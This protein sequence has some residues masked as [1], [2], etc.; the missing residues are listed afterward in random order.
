MNINKIITNVAKKYIGEKELPKNS[1]FINKKFEELM[2]TVGWISSYAWCSLFAELIWKEAYSQYDSTMINEIDNLFSASSVKTFN[3]FKNNK[4]WIVNDIPEIGSIV[5]WQNY[6]NN[7]PLYTGHTGIVVDIDEK[8]GTIKT[9]EGNTNE[10][11]SREG[12]GVYL[13]TRRYLNESKNF[14]LKGFI[15]PKSTN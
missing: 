14:R 12:E 4:N 1:G 6:K 11:G 9:V 10:A 3:N 2:T 13:K 8:S 7:K 15:H 5:T